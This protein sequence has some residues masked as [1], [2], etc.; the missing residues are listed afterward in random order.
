MKVL[1]TI[2][3]RLLV[4]AMLMSSVPLLVLGGYNLQAARVNLESAVWNHE[5]LVTM[6]IGEDISHI[7]E[8]A[9]RTFL[10]LAKTEGLGFADKTLRERERILYA[11]LTSLP[12]VDEIAAID[13]EGQ[14]LAKVSRFQLNTEDFLQQKN[15]KDTLK[16]LEP[17]KPLIGDVYMDEEKQP[18]FLLTLPFLS[19]DNRFTGGIV[20]KISLRSIIQQISLA[21][22]GKEESIFLVDQEGRLIGHKDYSQVLRQQDVSAS[23]P[24]AE[25]LKNIVDVK[26]PLVRNYQSYT[27]EKVVGAY[28]PVDGTQWAVIFEEP[29]QYAYESF[30]KLQRT[31]ALSTLGLVL[32]VLLIS[33]GFTLSFGRRLDLLKQGVSKIHQGEWGYTIPVKKEDEIGEVLHAF[34][35]LSEELER[36]KQ[37]EAAMRQADQMVTV[38]RLAAG[39]AHEINNPLATIYLSVE[40]LLERLEEGEESSEERKELHRY[41]KTIAEQAERCSGITRQLLDFAHQSRQEDIRESL[42]DLNDLIQ[43]NLGLIQFRLRKQQIRLEK[44]FT[45]NLPYLWGDESAIQQVIFNLICNAFTIIFYRNYYI[46]I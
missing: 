29:E 23:L 1:K 39:V 26:K 6:G 28:L 42:F 22:R 32:T 8:E 7:L 35:D 27:G 34:N 21:S 16:E 45:T 38:G 36:K 33:I 2:Q 4:F 46:I 13:K 20:A 9:K 44:N 19:S 10:I 5:T 18:A 30:A 40:E 14:V 12:Y 25:G 31:F 17:L 41:L 24:P 3:F 37:V 15:F 43:R 11:S